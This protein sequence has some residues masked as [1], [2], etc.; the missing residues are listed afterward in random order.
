[1]IKKILFV[2]NGISYVKSDL[3]ILSKHFNVKTYNFSSSKNPLK[4]LWEYVKFFFFLLLNINN[5]DLYFIWF[6][7]IHSFPAVFFAK[8]FKKKSVVNLGGYDVTYIPELN[9]GAFSNPVRAFLT[10]Y[11]IKNA[12][13]NLAV[14]KK[15][16]DE[17]IKRIKSANIKVVPTGYKISEIKI[18]ENKKNIVLTV[19][20]VD[21]YNR[22]KIKGIDLFCEVAK[23]MPNTKFIVV[24][25]SKEAES[26]LNNPPKNLITFPQLQI[27]KLQS[28]YKEAKV[29]AQFSMREGFPSAVCEAMLY[30]CIPVATNV[31]AIPEIIGNTGFII[32]N[33]ISPKNIKNL[34]LQAF[35]YTFADSLKASERIKNNFSLKHREQNLLEIL[36]TLK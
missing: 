33:D 28:F 32:K 18:P 4:M 3:E 27:E 17:A 23:L 25:I 26:F 13:I 11:S 21:S 1:M 22:F 34:I 20:R 10:G 6:A 36:K 16:K 8:I 29:Y 7:D 24:G 2:Y 5:Y 19:G 14:A 15:L 31:G 35:E 12:T 9:Y 30:G